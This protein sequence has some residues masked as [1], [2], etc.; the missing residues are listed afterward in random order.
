[1][2]SDIIIFGAGGHTRSLIPLIRANGYGISA[3]Y[4]N[5]FL[6]GEEEKID[7]VLIV[8]KI[9]AF[10]GDLKIVLSFGDG[11]IRSEFLNLFK[12]N[13]LNENL[14]HK[15]AIIESSTKIENSNQIFAGVL[16]NAQVK[17][18]TNNI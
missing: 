16:I 15:S 18:G 11:K 6:A 14:I 13:I 17:I 4:D 1:M 10:K 9:D 5:S 12:T 7:D 8:G 2:K 3:I